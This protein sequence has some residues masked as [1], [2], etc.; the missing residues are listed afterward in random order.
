MPEVRIRGDKLNTHISLFI[1]VA[2]HRNYSRFHPAIAVVVCQVQ[3]LP[4]DYDLLHAQQR[5][6]PVYRMRMGLY[7]KFFAPI[8]LS[9]YGHG[10]RDTHP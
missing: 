3:N 8:V 4:N 1:T 7:A 10:H 6:I 5:P 2:P 9:L